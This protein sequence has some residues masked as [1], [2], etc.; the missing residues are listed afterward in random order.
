MINA[1]DVTNNAIKDLQIF[2][3]FSSPFIVIKIHLKVNHFQRFL[4]FS[5]HL[6][7]I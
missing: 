5:Y 2:F 1:D 6:H 4:T 7:Y 3:I